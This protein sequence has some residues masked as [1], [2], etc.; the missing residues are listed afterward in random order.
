MPPTG[1]QGCC[2]V[3]SEEKKK[4]FVEF[5]AITAGQYKKIQGKK[6]RKELKEKKGVRKENNFWGKMQERILENSFL[7]CSILQKIS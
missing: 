3:D 6:E 4:Y 5:S 1:G 7:K 2:T